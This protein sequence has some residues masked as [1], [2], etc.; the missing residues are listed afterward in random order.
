M[1]ESEFV[2]QCCIESFGTQMT[3]ADQADAIQTAEA[4]IEKL[5]ASG[6][7]FSPQTVTQFG[8]HGGGPR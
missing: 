8:V 5:K 2:Q 3:T 7:S 1:T 4:F 6:Y